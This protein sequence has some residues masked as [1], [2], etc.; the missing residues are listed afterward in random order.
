LVIRL[1]KTK[2]K[3]ILVMMALIDDKNF[4]KIT[5]KYRCDD[6][7]IKQMREFIMTTMIPDEDIILNHCIVTVLDH[8]KRKLLPPRQTNYFDVVFYVMY[9][10]IGKTFVGEPVLE[11][12]YEAAEELTKEEFERRKDALPGEKVL[13]EAKKLINPTIKTN[14]NG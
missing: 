7:V 14:H 5:R 13:R 6:E 1:G 11:I 3:V 9:Y 2:R 8:S 12:T 10:Q 4:R